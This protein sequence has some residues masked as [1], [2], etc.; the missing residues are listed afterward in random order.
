VNFRS[1]KE[2]NIYLKTKKVRAVFNVNIGALTL[3]DN[4][5]LK[6]QI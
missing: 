4:M 3:G 1:E 5:H 6:L 2:E